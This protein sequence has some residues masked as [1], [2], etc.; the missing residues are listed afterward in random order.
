MLDD[1]RP[2]MISSPIVKIIKAVVLS[3]LMVKLEG[4]IEMFQVGL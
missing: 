2:V 4:M 3:E 1:L